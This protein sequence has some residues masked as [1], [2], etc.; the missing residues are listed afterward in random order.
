MAERLWVGTRKGLFELR[1]RAGQWVIE[2]VSFLGEPVSMVLP[3]PRDGHIYAALNLG[4]WGVKFHRSTDGGQTFEELEPM[5]YPP[6][7]EI[8]AEGEPPWSLEMIWS[9]EPGGADQPGT[10]YAGTIPG[11]L[12][13]SDDCGQSWTLNEAL[14]RHESRPRWMGGGYD[15]PGIHSILV[16][17]RDSQR[18]LLGISSAGVWLTEDGGRTWAPHCK[19]MVNNYMPPEL[20]EQEI[21]Q[22]PHRT[23][24]CPAQPDRLWSSHHCG[25]YHSAD[26]G[27]LWQQL[28]NCQPTCFGFAMAVHP[29]DPDTAWFVPEHSDM[30][31]IPA[32][33]QVVVARTSDGGASWQ[34]LRN[35][36]PQ[37]HAYDLVYRHGLDVAP[38]GETLALGSTTGTLWWSGDRGDG[39]RTISKHLPPIYCLRF[40]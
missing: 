6:Q 2:R 3:D 5:V 18:V 4:H 15:H 7:P 1:A 33:G 17:P 13:R 40:G 8:L 30:Q 10:I 34:V 29:T 20:Q 32:D 23:V 22:D 37:E 38:D 24:M 35:G 14:W 27:T 25:L 28:T 26:G 39:W 36:L 9:L 11:G 31:R 19:G 12:F 16:D 21:G